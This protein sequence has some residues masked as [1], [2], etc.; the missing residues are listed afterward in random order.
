M[1]SCGFLPAS[2]AAHFVVGLGFSFFVCA[3]YLSPAKT[4]LR[5]SKSFCAWVDFWKKL[6]T[7]LLVAAL[8]VYVSSQ[9]DLKQI[10]L[11]N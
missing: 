6:A 1:H 11:T 2:A 4:P 10:F 8:N 9:V 3:S 7:A 5:T